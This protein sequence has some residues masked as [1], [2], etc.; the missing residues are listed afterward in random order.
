MK[1]IR[2]SDGVYDLALQV[3][4]LQNRSLAQQVEHWVRLAVALEAAGVTVE[5]VQRI[6][7]GDLRE[8]ERAMMRLGLATQESM[9]LL[10]PEVARG[11]KVS[12]PSGAALDAR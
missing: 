6:L 5:Q 4:A 12:F 8:R 1:S 9:L 7:G 3:A 2:I 10:P 11:A